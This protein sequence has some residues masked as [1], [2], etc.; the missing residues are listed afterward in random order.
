VAAYAAPHNQ[1]V[2]AA[3]AMSAESASCGAD[4]VA[5]QQAFDKYNASE[6]SLRPELLAAI[7]RLHHEA[8]ETLVKIEDAP[9]MTLA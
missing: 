9:P 4:T 8:R 6:A 7:S 3:L 5:R 1:L 2:M